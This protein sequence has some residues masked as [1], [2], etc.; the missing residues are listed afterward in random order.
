[1][2]APLL[3]YGI[4]GWRSGFR[5]LEPRDECLLCL[6]CLCGTGFLDALETH[7]IARRKLPQFPQICSDDH[8]LDRRTLQGR[9]HRDPG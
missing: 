5:P 4:H 9:D 8:E 2:C 6:S 1:M 3:A 7:G